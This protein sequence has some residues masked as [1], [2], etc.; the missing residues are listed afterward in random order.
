[1]KAV[2][3]RASVA[4]FFLLAA[5]CS[6]TSRKWEY[7]QNLSPIMHTNSARLVL[8]TETGEA[9]FELEMIRTSSG[10]R[11]YLNILR[12][13]A[14]LHLDMDNKTELTITIGNNASILYP[15]VLKGG[16]RLLLPSDFY[17]T[18]I[19]AI[20]DDKKIKVGMGFRSFRLCST[21][22]KQSYKAFLT[23]PTTT[24]PRH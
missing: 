9:P 3:Q 4:L 1:M 8:A 6:D 24:S 2:F 14:P 12:F 10:L 19:Q 5:S 15:H 13:Q 17:E 11:I 16:Q 20:L 22:F 18:L 7:H 21:N 23:L